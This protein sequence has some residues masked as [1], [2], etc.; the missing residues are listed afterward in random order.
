MQV[1]PRK[2]TEKNIS[3]FPHKLGNS[4]GSGAKSYMT[5][6]LLIYG[7]KI[8]YFLIYKE[9]LPHIGLCTRSHLNI[10]IFEE[11]FVSFFISVY[12]VTFLNMHLSH[13]NVSFC[14]THSPSDRLHCKKKYRKQNIPAE[15][16]ITD[17]QKYH[18]CIIL[19]QLLII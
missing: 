5:N 18:Q 17:E 7:E 4:E 12:A 8:A 13:L 9:A 14:L 2:Y 1:L 11:S 16:S 6:G 15:K 10:L 3:N 19:P